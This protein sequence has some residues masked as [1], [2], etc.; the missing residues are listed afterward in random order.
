MDKEEARFQTFEYSH[1]RRKQVVRLHRKGI[2]VMRVIELNG[3]TYLAVRGA[4][5]RH[6]QGGS[7]AVKPKSLCRVGGKGHN[8]ADKQEKAV[9]KIICDKRAE[10]LKRELA[11][12]NRAA[13]M[14][15]IE[16]E[17]GIKLSVRCV[18]HYLKRWEFT[19]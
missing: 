16:R 2:G 10:Q 19:P 4:I 13:F 11:L 15:L 14:Q 9:R 1:E 7:A 8:V 17:C 3:L 12:W 18:G 5:D 6:A